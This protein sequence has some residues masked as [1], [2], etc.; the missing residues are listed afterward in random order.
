MPA[1]HV[2]IKN[3]NSFEQ[4][5]I[6]TLALAKGL[7]PATLPG[8][9]ED[10]IELHTNEIIVT[11]FHPCIFYLEAKYPYPNLIFGDIESQVAMLMVVDSLNYPLRKSPAPLKDLMEQTAC[12]NPFI[13]GDRPSLI[14]VAATHYKNVLPPTYQ[15]KVEKLLYQA[16]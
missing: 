14:D 10:A 9:D 8:K 12:A 15:Q 3:G 4:S 5:T 7:Q 13:L 16:L 1:P 6:K 11:G 2:T